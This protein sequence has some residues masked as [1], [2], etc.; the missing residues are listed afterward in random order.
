MQ[1]TA[2]TCLSLQEPWGEWEAGKH[3][4][5]NDIAERSGAQEVKGMAF[6]G[7]EGW[8]SDGIKALEKRRSRR[9]EDDG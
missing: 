7:W 9:G 4:G 3:R 2:P 5:L 6:V 8:G 1:I